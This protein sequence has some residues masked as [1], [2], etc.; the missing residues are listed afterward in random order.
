M[1]GSVAWRKSS[2]TQVILIVDDDAAVLATAVMLVESLGYRAETASNGSEALRMVM[3][4]DFDAVLTDVMMPDMNGF[5]LA[6]RIRAI[7]PGL[8]RDLRHWLC[9]CRRGV[10][11]TQRS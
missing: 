6:R 10:S 4:D 2:M 5:Q 8:P 1:T 3:A 7:K 11:F 9:Q